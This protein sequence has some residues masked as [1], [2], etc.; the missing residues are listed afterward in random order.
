VAPGSGDCPG[1]GPGASARA[2]G[3]R[4]LPSAGRSPCVGASLLDCARRELASIHRSLLH[5]QAS[6]LDPGYRS[7]ASSRT[8]LNPT[9]LRPTASS[10]S[11]A[12]TT[13]SQVAIED[14]TGDDNYVRIPRSDERPRPPSPLR[15]PTRPRRR[16]NQMRVCRQPRTDISCVPARHPVSS[17]AWAG[18][19]RPETDATRV[20]D[21]PASGPDVGRRSQGPAMVR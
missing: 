15:G 9:T 6:T 3:R 1:G 5:R 16:P 20:A 21:L 19:R 12:R 10:T 2:F 8:S 14:W 4:E 13:G 18:H 17:H 11:P 7:P